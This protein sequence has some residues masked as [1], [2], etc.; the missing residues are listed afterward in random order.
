M[1]YYTEQAPTRLIMQSQQEDKY[2]KDK[3]LESPTTGMEVLPVI[4]RNKGPARCYFLMMAK[5][6]GYEAS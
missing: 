6:P 2:M 5:G 3:A 4:P 1:S